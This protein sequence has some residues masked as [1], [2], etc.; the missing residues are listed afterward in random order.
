[1][2]MHVSLAKVSF[3]EKVVCRSEL[4]GLDQRLEIC[5]RDKCLGNIGIIY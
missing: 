2:I 4:P 5:L 1:M 3:Q